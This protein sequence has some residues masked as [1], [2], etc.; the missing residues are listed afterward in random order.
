MSESGTHSITE[1][2]LRVQA[3]DSQAAHE[4]WQR[5][6]ERMIRDARRALKGL[7]R[8]A[9]DEDD[10]A[11]EVFEA[12]LN[13]V[14][15]NRF[16]KLEGRNDLWQIL[17]MLAERKANSILRREL[18]KKRNE[19]K[20][21]G[22]SAFEQIDPNGSARPGIGEIPEPHPQTT[23]QLSIVVRELLEKLDDDSQRRVALDTLAGYKNKEI[24]ERMGI[25]LRSVERKL[26]L[27]RDIWEEEFQLDD[28]GEF[29]SKQE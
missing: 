7:P 18:A 22:E 27:I 29:E 1:M 26:G 20:E 5:S 6:L 10:V 2:V 14:K 12:F 25:S 23:E 9:V 15:E 24:A 3:G 16:R 21:R 11:N 28:T 4:L 13:G 17:A 19:G 8:R